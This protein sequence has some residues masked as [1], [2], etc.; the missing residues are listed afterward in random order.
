MGYNTVSS[1]FSIT[2]PLTG[3]KADASNSSDTHSS[4]SSPVPKL[5]V[6]VRGWFISSWS[7]LWVQ[8]IAHCLCWGPWNKLSFHFLAQYMEFGKNKEYHP[9]VPHLL[10]APEKSLRWTQ[11]VVRRMCVQDQFLAVHRLS[12]ESQRLS[13]MLVPQLHTLSSVFFSS[14]LNFL[15]FLHGP[16]CGFTILIPVLSSS[17]TSVPS[18]CSQEFPLHFL[19]RRNFFPSALAKQTLPRLSTCRN[20]SFRRALCCCVRPH[21]TGTWSSQGQ[22]TKLFPHILGTSWD[23][24]S[25]PPPVSRGIPSITKTASGCRILIQEGCGA[26]GWGRCTSVMD[27]GPLGTN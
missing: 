18:L 21:L 8:H 11:V 4:F 1:L 27:T 6:C 2:S 23:N 16:P 26:S 24:T 17:G 25:N 12:S 9:H 14:W 22:Q 19:Q 15:T 20:S 7:T 13:V 10:H 5:H 3:G